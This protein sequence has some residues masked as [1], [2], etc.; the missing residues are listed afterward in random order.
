MYNIAVLG[1]GIVGVSTAV[2]IQ[3]KL[4]GAKVRVISDRFDQDTT[5]WGAGGIFLP[6]TTRIQG[7]D[8]ARLK[9]YAKDAWDQ[10]SSIATSELACETGIQVVSGYV[11]FKQEP[12]IPLYADYVYSFR[13]MTKDE[14]E[15]QKL[16]DY[17]YGF[18][19]QTLVVTVKK[20]YPWLLKRQKD[21]YNLNNSNA[22]TNSI[23]QRCERL[24]P[25]VKVVHNY[26]HGSNGI[27]LSWGSSLE[28][29]Q[30]IIS[31]LSSKSKL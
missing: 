7:L 14:L 16:S 9:K 23:L 17:N 2:N 10:Y 28:A 26:G 15:R 21:N 30:L 22:D 24:V 29:L 20:Y 8:E 19:V 11:L 6:T 4:P 5:S 27:I 3:K 25:A 1:A 18:Y 12:Q 13:K 31:S